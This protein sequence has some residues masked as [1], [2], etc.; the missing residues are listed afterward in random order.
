M[1]G[2]PLHPVI[3]LE[4]SVF[5]VGPLQIERK[6]RPNLK[7]VMTGCPETEHACSFRATPWKIKG[8]EPTAITHEKKET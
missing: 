2:M 1:L 8:L 6:K 3:P 7:E 5:I 4:V